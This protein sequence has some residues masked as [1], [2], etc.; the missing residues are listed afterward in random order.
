MLRS[1]PGPWVRCGST[2]YGA[3]C[4]QKPAGR[5]QSQRDVA[6]AWDKFLHLVPS[7]SLHCVT[8]PCT[9]LRGRSSWTPRT[10]AC[11]KFNSVGSVKRLA[12]SSSMRLSQSYY[13]LVDPPMTVHSSQMTL[14]GHVR[15]DNRPHW[16]PQAECCHP[17][18]LFL[19]WPQYTGDPT[20]ERSQEGQPS[21]GR[22]HD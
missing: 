5:A 1:L 12:E 6:V 18:S 13:Y 22:S 19:C 4:G 14:G 20:L 8:F 3:S 21:A 2:S 11:D 7:K 9:A 17:A 10:P 16:S 15:S